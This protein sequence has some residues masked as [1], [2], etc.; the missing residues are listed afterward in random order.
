[1]AHEASEQRRWGFCGQS[2]RTPLRDSLP[3]AMRLNI[4][5]L[6]N[7]LERK[8]PIALVFPE[9]PSLRIQEPSAAQNCLGAKISFEIPEGIL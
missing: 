6:A 3:D 1:M 4:E 5:D 2:L 9:Q 8:Q 7:G